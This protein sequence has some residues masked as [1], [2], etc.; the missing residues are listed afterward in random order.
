MNET[1]VCAAA[2]AEGLTLVPKVNKSGFKGV[3]PTGR[4]FT[5]HVQNGPLGTFDTAPEAA[6]AVA[7]QL[8]PEASAA[9]VAA[10]V[11]AVAP[12]SEAA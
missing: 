10:A 12:M 7:R 4:R 5:A 11:P 8:G 6:L 3:Q 1:A 9:A 2:E